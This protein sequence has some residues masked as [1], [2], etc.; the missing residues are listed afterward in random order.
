[1]FFS[2]LIN[3]YPSDK[4]TPRLEIHFLP[5]P[6]SNNANILLLSFVGQTELLK[7]RKVYS[8]VLYKYI[9]VRKYA[10]YISRLIYPEH[11]NLVD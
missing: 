3:Q 9:I 1:M 5:A 6:L 8:A 10:R 2:L 11:Q 7:N 4:S